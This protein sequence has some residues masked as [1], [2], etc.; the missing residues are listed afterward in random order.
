MTGGSLKLRLL[1]LGGV[2]IGLALLIAGLGMAALFERHAERRAVAELDTY[3]RQISAGVT[4]DAKGTIAFK[5]T[6]PDPRFGEPLSGLYWQIEDETQKQLLRSRSL[7]DAV[8]RLPEDVLD[9]G[10]VHLHTIE[11]PAHSELLARERSISYATPAG[12][13]RVRISV[14][15]DTREI[16]AARAEFQLGCRKGPGTSRHRF[17]GRGVGTDYPRLETPENAA[18]KRA[19]GPVGS[20]DAHRRDR[21]P[22]SH[23]AGLGGQFPARRAS[24]RRWKTRRQGLPISR[25]VS[26]HR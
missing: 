25:T 4:F 12:T 19:R 14:A 24:A 13:H 7:W 15:L 10:K 23:A 17:D 11:G 22:G 16:H 3:V 6:L 26:K 1:V 21:A 20:R 18:G 5:R 8:L 9:V 2:T